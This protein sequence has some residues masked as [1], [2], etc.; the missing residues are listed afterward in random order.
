MNIYLI[1][2][3][4]ILA[5]ILGLA[6]YAFYMRK[7]IIAAM[8]AQARGEAPKPG[9]AAAQISEKLKT[10]IS[11]LPAVQR[12]QAK[13][14]MRMTRLEEVRKLQAQKL[15]PHE[16]MKALETIPQVKVLQEEMQKKIMEL[17]E[18]IDLQK[19]LGA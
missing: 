7:Q 11:R 16:F 2:G 13:Y 18:V 5:A 4:I 6:G 9:S 17:S 1:V 19:K 8:E 14:G 10:Q 3:G 12:L 15:T